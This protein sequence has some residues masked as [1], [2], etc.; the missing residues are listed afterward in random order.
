MIVLWLVGR[1]VDIEQDHTVHDLTHT[2]T[3]HQWQCLY[4]PNSSLAIDTPVTGS[5]EMC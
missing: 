5:L 2:H 1:S 4:L 3:H